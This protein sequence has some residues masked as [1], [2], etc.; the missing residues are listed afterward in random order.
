MQQKWQIWTAPLFRGVW[1]SSPQ[2]FSINITCVWKLQLTATGSQCRVVHLEHIL[3]SAGQKLILYS[4]SLK[5]SCTVVY[6]LYNASVDRYAI[7]NTLSFFFLFK[8][9]VLSCP[10]GTTL[11]WHRSFVPVIFHLMLHKWPESTWTTWKTTVLLL[12]PL[13][14]LFYLYTVMDL[15]SM[16]DFIYVALMHPSIIS[17]CLHEAVCRAKANA[18]T[19]CTR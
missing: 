17:L 10:V 9:T 13:L 2:W 7:G 3:G 12:F 1:V 8:D 14:E 4:N 6:F 18:N 16:D 11:Q 5:R 15:Q 19:H